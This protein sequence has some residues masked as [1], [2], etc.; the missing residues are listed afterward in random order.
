[1]RTDRNA[2]SRDVIPLIDQFYVPRDERFGHL[3]KA[4]FGAYAIKAITTAI[5]PLLRAGFDRV[6]QW[7]FDNFDDIL[8][9]Y[10]G[11][12]KL[13]GCPALDE[14]RKNFI[15]KLPV[16]QIIKE[17]KLAWRTDEEFGR[18]M[19]AGVNP[20]II[21]RLTVRCLLYRLFAL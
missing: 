14:L 9:L 2:E 11:G 7:E 17:N 18:E 21:T 1:M 3:K 10:E 19:L 8:K 6:S 15:L 5:L 16:P 12:L 4:D 20:L 13:P